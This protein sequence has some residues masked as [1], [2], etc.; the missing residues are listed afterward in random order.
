MPRYTIFLYLLFALTLT[1]CGTIT[2]QDNP[3]PTA[4]PPIVV[5][6]SNLGNVQLQTIEQI[7]DD[8]NIS[9]W[10][11]N[12]TGLDVTI[13]VLDLGFGGLADFEATYGVD[14]SL[15]RG[16]DPTAYIDNPLRHGTQVLEVIHLIAPNA[17]LVV[18][19]YRGFD[20]F[21]RCVNTMITRGVDIVNHSAGVPALPLDGNGQWADVVTAV[22][23]RG[24]L[25][26][27]SAGN[28]AGG[29]LNNAFT[30]LDNNRLHEF[31]GVPIEQAEAL[32][33]DGVETS[34]TIILS[35]RDRDAIPANQIDLDLQILSLP[36][37]TPMTGSYDEQTGLPSQQPLELVVLDMSQDFAVQ[38]IG[39]D[40]AVGTEFKLFVEFAR[41]PEGD[42]FSSI[43]APADA[44]EALT[45]AALQ[46]FSPAPYS[47]RGPLE[48]GEDKPDIAVAGEIML[49][50]GQF[51]GTSAAAPVIAGTAAL[52]WE[53]SPDWTRQQVYDY[54]ID[55]TLSVGGVFA[56]GNGRLLLPNAD[57]LDSVD[58]DPV[59]TATSESA[60]DA[61][62]SLFGAGVEQLDTLILNPRAQLPVVSDT[63]CVRRGETVHV[64]ANG[65]IIF[66]EFVGGGG[67]DGP[68][69]GG[70][71]A[72][73]G[74]NIVPS[75]PHGI[76]MCRIAG[77]ASWAIC[78]EQAIF[79]AERD[80]CV[81]FTINDND[82]NDNSGFFE[83][84]V[85]VER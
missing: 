26:V 60:Q 46:G 42:E 49:P 28:F 7:M 6:S 52:I 39:N 50:S 34:G 38:V 41:V 5:S 3:A 18:C 22:S 36:D 85:G 20:S 78:G 44:S 30:D 48:G 68:T 69:A 56:T 14:V 4:V 45:V 8:A 57:E 62:A 27:N 73:G 77:E 37:G 76:L 16:A 12:Y 74:F 40:N 65:E 58:R 71:A 29:A 82:L 33:I 72:L 21:N 23:E 54:L 43:I 11:E 1:A 17:E 25:W 81:E 2:A 84:S 66:G 9:S 53:A 59:P 35:W 79:Q 15:P 51:V 61:E 32:G 19:Q 47:S 55:N 80:G 13:G 63:A 83:I 75:L 31:R 24:I 70:W 67:P 10:R 64:L